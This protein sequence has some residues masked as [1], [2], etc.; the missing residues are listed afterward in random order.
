MVFLVLTACEKPPPQDVP[1]TEDRS[2]AKGRTLHKQ[3]VWAWM[4]AGEQE[5]LATAYDWVVFK[6]PPKNRSAMARKAKETLEKIPEH[7]NPVRILSEVLVA[8]ADVEAKRIISKN[9]NE[10]FDP[11]IHKNMGLTAVANTCLANF[12]IEN[13]EE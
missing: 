13:R 6:T 8:C 2:W 4:L 7:N 11:S 9:P 10:S 5:K 12:K 3:S 1:P